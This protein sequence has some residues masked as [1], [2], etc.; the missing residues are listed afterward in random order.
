MK[1]T[2]L[3]QMQDQMVRK[4]G[5]ERGGRISQAMEQEFAVLCQND[6]NKPKDMVHHLHNNIYPVVAAYR[7]LMADGMAQEEASELAQSAFL[8]LMEEPKAS[9]Q[10]LCRIPGVYRLIPLLFEK[11]MPVLFKKEAGF[12][13]VYHPTNHRRARFDML[14][15]PYL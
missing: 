4:L 1:K 8:E 11:L 7:T 12:E 9:I 5:E 15:C 2:R 10:K 14:A 3:S 6:G 13:F